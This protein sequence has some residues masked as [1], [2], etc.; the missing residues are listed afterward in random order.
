MDFGNTKTPSM[1]CR[2]GSA[3][4]LLMA[5]P[6]ESDLDFPW[7]KSQRDNR[8]VLKKQTNIKQFLCNAQSAGAGR[9]H[10]DTVEYIVITSLWD[11]YRAVNHCT[12]G[13]IYHARVDCIMLLCSWL[14]F[15]T[16]NDWVKCSFSC[17]CMSGGRENPSATGI[18]VWLCH[19]QAAVAI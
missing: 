5:F 10:G 16:T 1:H 14:I 12:F 2:L 4:L 6:R 18:V 8:V 13:V 9:S 17:M 19:S 15:Y 3:T 7:E 11:L